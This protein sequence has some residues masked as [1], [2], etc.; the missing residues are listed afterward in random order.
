MPT[1]IVAGNWKMN[2]TLEEA[3]ALARSVAEGADAG[4]GVE[5]VLC[6]PSIALKLVS[7]AVAG[8]P[9][10]VGA[11]NMHFEDAGAFTG[12]IAPP[13]LKG[14]CQYVIIGHSERR[15]GFGETDEIV[16]RKTLAALRHG[17]QP[18]LCVG[19]TLEQRA[20]GQA[21]DVI[22]GQVKAGLAGA[23]EADLSRLIVAYEPI[24]AIGAGQAATPEIAAEIMNGA[25]R[26]SLKSLGGALADD[27]PLLYGGS[28]SPTNIADFAA[29][30]CIHGAL[31]GGASLQAQSFLDIARLAGQSKDAG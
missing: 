24:W 16:N 31:V 3:V 22:A 7:D 6:P 17:L 8:S 20:A 5:L 18:I 19:E 4:A 21:A 30:Q 29:Q 15:Q 13:M 10:K 25:V 26:C 28:V 14:I 12:E 2:K 11:Q 27:I 23:A 1:T 9:V